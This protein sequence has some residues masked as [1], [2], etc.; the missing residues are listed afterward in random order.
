MPKLASLPANG[1]LKLTSPTALLGL[2]VS[3][4]QSNT[5]RATQFIIFESGRLQH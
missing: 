5:F 3:E 1:A 2:M 4:A